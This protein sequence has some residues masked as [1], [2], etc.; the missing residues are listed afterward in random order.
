MAIPSEITTIVFDWGDTL[1][2]TD[3]RYSGVMAEWPEV[4]A[5]PGARE[6]LEAL[7]GRFHLAIATNAV[8]SSAAQVRAALDRVGLAYPIRDIFTFN[9]LGARKPEPLFFQRA[10]QLLGAAPQQLVMVGDSYSIDVPGARRA[11]WR[12]AWYNPAGKPAPGPA[13]LHDLEFDNLAELPSALERLDLPDLL[14]CQTWY[15]DQEGVGSLWQ[16]VEAVGMASYHLAVL[17]RAAGHAVDPL[18][19]HRGGLLHD[20]AKISSKR[21]SGNHGEMGAEILTRLG[22]PVLAEISRRHMLFYLHDPRK[23]PQTWEEKIVHFTDKI[24]EGP[25]FVEWSERLLG[26]AT[27]Y[28]SQIEAMRNCTPAVMALQDE[29]ATAAGFPSSEMVARLR[30]AISQ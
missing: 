25:R 2:A 5:V 28:P 11:G 15:L 18:L 6:A 21:T 1:M 13:P 29:L 20:I 26:L 12:A 24:C 19:A 22:Q 9:E 3:A 8:D 7:Q 10:A 4:R 14:T 27:R 30:Q 23:R 17:L 16:H